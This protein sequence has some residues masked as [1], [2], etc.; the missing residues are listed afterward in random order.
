MYL[1]NTEL[2]INWTLYSEVAPPT[3]EDLSVIQHDPNNNISN[4]VIQLGDYIPCCIRKLGYVTYKFT[5]TTIGLWQVELKV[6]NVS[7]GKH[8]ILVDIND[9]TIEKFLNI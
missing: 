4:E 7:V 1:V 2:N 9:T 6:S 3:L 5:P 8:D